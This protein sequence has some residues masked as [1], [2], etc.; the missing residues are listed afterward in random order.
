MATVAAIQ[1]HL[2]VHDGP[3]S[4]RSFNP[5]G[6]LGVR[7]TSIAVVIVSYATVMVNF[8]ACVGCSNRWSRNKEKSFYRLP[9]VIVHKYCYCSAAA[10]RA[11]FILILIVRTHFVFSMVHGYYYIIIIYL[12]YKEI[13]LFLHSSLLKVLLQQES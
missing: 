12:L 7:T 2:L 4:G 9:T 1:S 8:C 10:S 6:H 3:C 13:S 11:L 5:H